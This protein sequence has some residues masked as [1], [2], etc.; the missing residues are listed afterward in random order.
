MEKAM[1]DLA[2]RGMSLIF[3]LRDLLS[4][5]RKVLQEVDIQPG[6]TVLDYG[7]GP[8][9]YVPDLA[10]RVGA[11]GVVYALDLHPLAIESVRDR[12]QKR[13]LENV[14]T[15]LSNCQTGWLSMAAG[16]RS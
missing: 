12:V 16:I 10:E 13:G 11:T 2:F 4:P 7:C 9:A 14:E 8:G 3:G 6:D 5:R 1:P 15:I